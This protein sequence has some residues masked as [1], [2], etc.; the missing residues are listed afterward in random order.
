MEKG[1]TYYGKDIEDPEEEV[2]MPDVEFLR[3]DLCTKTG[4][5]EEAEEQLERLK[6]KYPDDERLE[7]YK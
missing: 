3:L 1:W 6:K 7:Q 2:N 4:H 5:A